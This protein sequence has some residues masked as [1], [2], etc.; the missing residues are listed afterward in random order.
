MTIDSMSTS[1]HKTFC[2]IC[3]AQCGLIVSTEANRVTAIEPN[4]DH[5]ASQ[6]YACIK[7]LRMADFAHSPDRLTT[8]LKKV[9]GRFEP[10]GWPQALSEI[11]AKLRDIHARHGGEAIAA[12]IGNPIAFSLWP[13]TMLALLLKD[14][15][16]AAT[17]RQPMEFAGNLNRATRGTGGRTEAG[18]SNQ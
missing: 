2:R 6:G 13:T 7:G 18:V 4:R 15:I 8:P 10:I 1:R 17:G 16:V 14:Y 9:N 5:V 11:G 3:E 12:Y